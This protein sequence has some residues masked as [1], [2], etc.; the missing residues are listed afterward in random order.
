MSLRDC[1]PEGKTVI[2][3]IWVKTDFYKSINV[4]REMA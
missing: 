1:K 4:K 2:C 3:E